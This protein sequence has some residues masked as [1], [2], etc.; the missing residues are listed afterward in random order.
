MINY[1][2]HS[3]ALSRIID[4]IAHQRPHPRFAERTVGKCLTEGKARLLHPA[5]PLPTTHL[6]LPV[7]ADKTA[8]IR[9]DRNQYSVPWQ[10]A[11][12]T[13]TLVADDIEVCLIDGEEEVASHLRRWGKGEWVEERAHRETLVKERCAARESKGPRS[14]L[15]GGARIR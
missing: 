12:Q 11:S 4:T 5:M 3:R 9:F 14:P 6:V 2:T 10:Q 8:F 13:L 15:H 7:R 1:V